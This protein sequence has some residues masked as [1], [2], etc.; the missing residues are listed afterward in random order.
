MDSRRL[1]LPVFLP[2]L[3]LLSA[4]GAPGLD[5]WG[6]QREVFGSENYY[7]TVEFSGSPDGVL[8]PPTP[9]RFNGSLVTEKG[10]YRVVGSR[11][12]DGKHWVYDL[13]SKAGS[14]QGRL[15]TSRCPAS[16]TLTPPTSEFPTER[17][18]AGTCY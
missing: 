5:R 18:R 15:E 12:R 11:R 10:E 13:T 2:S 9:A 16:M 8:S 4:V 1:F 17:L 14:F 7:L 6:H 3:C